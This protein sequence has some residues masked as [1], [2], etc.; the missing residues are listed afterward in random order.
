MICLIALFLFYVQYVMSA[1]TLYPVKIGETLILDIGGDVREW[2]RIRSGV[3]E[4]IVPCSE[5][6]KTLC[7]VWIDNNSKVTGDGREQMNKNGT[8][9]ISD[10]KRSD[11]G[12][13]FS[14]DELERV[15]YTADGQIWKLAKSRISIVPTD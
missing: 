1:V 6:V 8:L 13:Y 12:D 3:E 2:T 5:S 10:I 4:K 14:N 11:S 9:I 7:N 15:H